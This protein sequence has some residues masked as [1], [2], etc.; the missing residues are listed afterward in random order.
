MVAS[1][2]SQSV[3]REIGRWSES[4]SRFLSILQWITWDAMTPVAK[5]RS[6]VVSPPFHQW[7]GVPGTVS[8]CRPNSSMTASR[9]WAL[10]PY[11]DRRCS[12]DH[13]GWWRLKS[14]R[15]TISLFGSS[16]RMASASVE[17]VS[18]PTSL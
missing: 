4:Q 12:A 14:P 7:V 11:P 16:S 10:G 13:R 5:A 2:Q 17:I 9:G 6:I 8:S 1:F 15:T 3:A 18:V